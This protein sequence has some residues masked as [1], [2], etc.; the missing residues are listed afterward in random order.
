MRLGQLIART[1]VR[2]VAWIVISAIVYAALSWFAPAHAA[3]NGSQCTDRASA[4]ALAQSRAR[5]YA[6]PNGRVE[7]G[8]VTRGH[9]TDRGENW[10][11]VF[12]GWDPEGR[13]IDALAYWPV[14]SDCPNGG[15]WDDSSQSCKKQ[16]IGQPDVTVNRPPFL[17]AGMGNPSSFGQ[18]S[19][20]CYV[21]FQNMHDG[22]YVGVHVSNAAC[23]TP[24]LPDSE[25]CAAV[26]R[27]SGPWGCMDAP[28]ECTGDQIKD[29]LTG[30]CKAGCPAGMVVTLEGSCKPQADTC[31]PG[32][33]KSPVGGCLPGEGTCAAGEAR[34][35]DGT[36]KR[37]SDGDGTPDSEQGGEGD[38]DEGDG[39][40]F[41]GGD[42]CSRPPSCSG[43]P[44]MCGQARIQWRIEC[45]T[46]RKVNISGGTCGAMPVC[47]G[48]NCNAM[49]YAQLI[50][51]W[52]AAC[53]LEK[54]STGDTGPGGDGDGDG[55]LD[56][57]K[58][59]RDADT[60][61]A[62]HIAAQGDGLEGVNV[63]DVW[64]KPQDGDG[65]GIRDNLFGGGSPAQCSIPGGW[66]IAGQ[67]ITPPAPF[68]TLM[69]WLGWLFPALAYLWL[70]Q[71][72]GD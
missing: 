46:R 20:G 18:C 36:C 47:T 24:G 23:D 4:Y 55:L 34:G 57:M 16:C 44:V 54:L 48:E 31:P 58:G 15:T 30:E 52:K 71:K 68:W 41:A 22:T 67:D 11:V 19:G 32:Q 1:A 21:Q 37:D 56:W 39:T 35:K 8:D 27:V 17:P 61:A 13:R 5:D 38:D 43:S 33:I 9:W 2:R 12:R 60:Q 49:E 42:D 7:F 29:P 70:A 26:G 62:N 64:R 72:L 69:N 45:N 65:Q 25:T 10:R 6:G 63:D 14:G 50:Q 51:Q 28:K 3:C 59:V 66:T 53:A 40:E